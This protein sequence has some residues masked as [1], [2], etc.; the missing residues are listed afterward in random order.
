MGLSHIDGI[1]QCR[2]GSS[3]WPGRPFSGLQAVDKT[4]GR[5]RFQ[6]QKTLPQNAHHRG[7]GPREG[8]HR[9]VGR[10]RSL[11]VRRATRASSGLKSAC[12]GPEKPASADLTGDVRPGFL[13]FLPCQRKN[14]AGNPHTLIESVLSQKR[15]FRAAPG[16]QRSCRPP[17]SCSGAGGRGL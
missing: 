4:L 3:P 16:S 6:D 9:T 15:S 7:R 11:P 14:L 12:H 5:H 8:S 13:R 1:F 10:R 17:G 2:P